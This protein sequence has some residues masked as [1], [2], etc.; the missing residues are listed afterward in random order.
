MSLARPVSF[1]V[2]FALSYKTVVMLV[3]TS[4]PGTGVRT[5]VRKRLIMDTSM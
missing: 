2:A 3:S 5:P 4:D 1:P